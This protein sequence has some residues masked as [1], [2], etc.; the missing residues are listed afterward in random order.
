MAEPNVASPGVAVCEPEGGASGVLKGG[1]P[2]G[3]KGGAPGII[4]RQ[5]NVDKRHFIQ[6][7]CQERCRRTQVLAKVASQGVAAYQVVVA[8]LEEVERACPGATCRGA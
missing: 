6:S 8:F 7:V 2:G 3:A 5:I 1:A 4:L